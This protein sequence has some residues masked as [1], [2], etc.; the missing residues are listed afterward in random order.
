M[1]KP[2]LIDAIREKSTGLTRLQAAN[3]VDAMIEAMT[4]ALAQG[5]KVEIRGFGNF[6]VRQREARKARN[7]RTGEMVEVPAKRVPHFKPGKK[8]RA[9]VEGE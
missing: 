8:L 4:T 2:Q 1:T 7:P 5:S 6:T 9:M 3:V